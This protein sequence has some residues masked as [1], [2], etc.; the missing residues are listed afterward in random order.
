MSQSRKSEYDRDL[1]LRL[2]RAASHDQPI[3]AESH[4]VDD[5]ELLACW[6]AGLLT[7][8]Q[9]TE[10]VA[11]LADCPRCR[12]EL[13]GMIR[14]GDMQWGEP[15]PESATVCASAADRRRSLSV[16]LSLAVAAS[17]LAAASLLGWSAWRP[18]GGRGIEVGSA[19]AMRGKITDYGYLLDGQS[20]AKGFAPLDAELERQRKELLAAMEVKPGDRVARLTYGE[21]LLRLDEP[22]EAAGVFEELVEAA[23][24]EPSGRLGLG[25]ARFL[26]GRTAEALIEFQAVLQSEPENVA[27]KL[28][29]AACLAQLQRTAEAERYWR[30]VLGQTT[31]AELRNRIEQT[32]RLVRG[33]PAE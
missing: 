25:L 19:L 3:P 20:V 24:R 5:E 16:W 22:A 30:K 17:L 2:L 15:E 23:P 7:S 10:I 6:E 13:A 29:A 1:V 14:R 26:Q 9:R 8:R 27:A 28:N 12:H 31:D 11:H 4:L 21:L 18:G 32:L 33:R